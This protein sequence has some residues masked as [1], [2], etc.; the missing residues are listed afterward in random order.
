MIFSFVL[1]F[2]HFCLLGVTKRLME[3]WL[4]GDLNS[5]LGLGMREELSNR[6]EALKKYV[7]SEFQ[8]KSRSIRRKYF[9]LIYI[10]FAIPRERKK[11][12]TH[13]QKKL[14]RNVFFFINSPLY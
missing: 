8:R 9:S 5:R 6:M 4:S 3:W 12:C 7:P 2:M 13:T 1:D 14:E 10:P 11:I